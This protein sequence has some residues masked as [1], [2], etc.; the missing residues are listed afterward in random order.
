MYACTIQPPLLQ[1]EL[2]FIYYL[3]YSLFDCL[4]SLILKSYYKKSNLSNIPYTGI[5]LEKDSY[6]SDVPIRGITMC[7]F[8]ILCVPN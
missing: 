1:S 5:D 3:R 6:A 7:G 2:N 8:F 4:A